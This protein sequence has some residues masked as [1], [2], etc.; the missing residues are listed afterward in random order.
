VYSA[1]FKNEQ[2]LDHRTLMPVKPFAAAPEPLKGVT[3]HDQTWPCIHWFR[4]TF[5][6][7]VI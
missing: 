3:V 2:T 4:W 1:P 6:T 5:W 7:F